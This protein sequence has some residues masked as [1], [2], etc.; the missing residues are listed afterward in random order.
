MVGCFSLS[1]VGASHSD[2]TIRDISKQVTLVEVTVTYL[3][4]RAELC[5]SLK[6]LHHTSIKSA[7]PMTSPQSSHRPGVPLLKDEHAS[8][9]LNIPP[10]FV[11]LLN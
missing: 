8:L 3:S 9:E 10:T 7:E 1:E 11:I 5:C 2:A 4:P 6:R